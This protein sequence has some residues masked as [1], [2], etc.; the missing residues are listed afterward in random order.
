MWFQSSPSE[1]AKMQEDPETSVFLDTFTSNGAET[2]K[3]YLKGKFEIQEN[4]ESLDIAVPRFYN[5]IMAFNNPLRNE[6]EDRGKVLDFMDIKSGENV[7]DIGAG[8]GF[9]TI[10]IAKRVGDKGKV[11]AI[12]TNPLVLEYLRKVAQKAGYENRI[13]LVESSP[14]NI[15]LAPGSI[16]KAFLSSVW[17]YVD[18]V[19]GEKIRNAFAESI[20]TSLVEEGMLTVC[21]NR[22]DPVQ[23]ALLSVAKNGIFIKAIEPERLAQELKQFG[24][25]QTKKLN[26]SLKRYCLNFKVD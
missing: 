20:H 4:T 19:L 8:G 25:I 23:K 9:W 14:D 2:L 10:E 24:F 22:P 1:Q 12:D 13:V 6:I 17:H 18:Q 21:E 5:D 26:L 3:Y 16:K 15:K 11:F 7:A